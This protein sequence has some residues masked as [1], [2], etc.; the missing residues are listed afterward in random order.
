MISVCGSTSSIPAMLS[1]V[2][3]HTEYRPRSRRLMYVLSSRAAAASASSLH[4]A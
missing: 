3:I 2:L 1:S 4:P